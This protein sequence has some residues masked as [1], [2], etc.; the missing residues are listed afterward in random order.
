MLAYRKGE[1]APEEY[2]RA[3]DDTF[4]LSGVQEEYHLY[5]KVEQRSEAEREK[6]ER[7]KLDKEK[8]EKEIE[9]TTLECDL[10]ATQLEYLPKHHHSLIGRIETKEEEHRQVKEHISRLHQYN[11]AKD[12]AQALLGQLAILEGC[13]TRELYPKF[14]L[15][16]TD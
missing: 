16:L 1:E 14:G 4:K 5:R 12:L 2:E 11:E 3:S 13:T 8:L 7:E 10:L 9:R 15:S 6:I